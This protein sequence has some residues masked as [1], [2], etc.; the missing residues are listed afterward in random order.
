MVEI[1]TTDADEQTHS[2]TFNSS[3]ST[4]L[5]VVR[6]SPFGMTAGQMCETKTAVS[7]TISLAVIPSTDFCRTTNLDNDS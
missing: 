5:F 3:T 6:I 4:M 1:T 7:M 2:S